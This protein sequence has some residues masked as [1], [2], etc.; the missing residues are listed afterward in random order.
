[1]IDAEGR[2]APLVVTERTVFESSVSYGRDT[3]HSWLLVFLGLGLVVAGLIALPALRARP[4]SRAGGVALVV[5]TVWALSV[6][7]IGLAL[8]SL[9]AL[10]NHWIAYWN[11]NLF[12]FNPLALPLVV[13]L[14]ALARGKP[15]AG[16]ISLVLAGAMV[17]LSILGLVVQ[18]LP[19]FSQVNG[20]VIAFALP[21][22]LAIWWTVAR[23]S[24]TVN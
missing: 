24:R 18:V 2:E 22:N 6:G 14:P 9:W 12:F 21:P 15:W 11:E 5:P 16:R 20:G 8:A 3:P 1:V 10:T 23:L 19:W 7:L 17:L 13:T 4:A